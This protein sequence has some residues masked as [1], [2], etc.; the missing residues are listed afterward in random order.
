VGRRKWSYLAF[1]AVHAHEWLRETSVQVGGWDRAL[2][3]PRGC[4][5]GGSGVRLAATTFIQR[6]D[7]AQEST[8]T[9]LA[10]VSATH[11]ACQRTRRTS[12]TASSP[13]ATTKREARR[14]QRCRDIIESNLPAGTRAEREESEKR[15]GRKGKEG[16]MIP[17]ATRGD[18]LYSSGVSA[19][20]QKS[21]HSK[22]PEIPKVQRFQKSR[23]PKV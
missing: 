5:S 17:G 13:S 19:A 11:A 6:R 2:H 16:M 7:I 15:K 23:V 20:F 4:Q 9:N 18:L 1:T 14:C 10:H 21:R 3:P 8:N 22:G 12:W